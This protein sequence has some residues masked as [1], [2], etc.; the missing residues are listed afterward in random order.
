MQISTMIASLCGMVKVSVVSKATPMVAVRP[1]R[2]PMTMPRK[3]A[4]ITLKSVCGFMNPTKAPPSW[5]RL[6]SI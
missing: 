1:G 3:V 6:S 2:A 5:P 4:H